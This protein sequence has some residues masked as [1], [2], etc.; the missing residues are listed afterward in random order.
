MHT[1]EIKKELKAYVVREDSE[2]SCAIVFATNGAAAR[3]D[4]GNELNI[5]FEEVDSCRREPAFDQYAPGPVPLHATLA[6]GWRHECSHCGARFDQDERNYGDDEDREDAFEPV[7]DANCYTFCS[8]T[9]MMQHWAERR[10]RKAREC[11]AIEAA[12]TR[13]PMAAGVTAGE[14]YKGWPSNGYEMRA[15][16]MLPG[17][18]YP[19]TWAPGD[20]TAMVSQCDVDEFTRLYGIK[21]PAQ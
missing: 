3:R 12:L 6:A 2:G 9:C 15:Q 10:E 11:S 20:S 7:Q 21:E 14:Y 8:P 18:K 16:F 17:L 1:A 5:S 4:G 13:W 19:V